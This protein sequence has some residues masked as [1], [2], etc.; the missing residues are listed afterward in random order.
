MSLNDILQI[1]KERVRRE[2]VVLNTVYERM[3]NRINLAVRATSKECIYTIPEFIPGY[4]LINVEKTKNYLLAKLK[5]EGF[6]AFAYNLQIYITWDP[7]DIK[8]LD[9]EIKR[10]TRQTIDEKVFE[11]KNINSQ[12]DFIQSLIISKQNDKYI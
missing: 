3:Q 4:P 1:E 7:K 8:R 5:K 2:R 6:I 9:E 10:Q 12:D 11:R